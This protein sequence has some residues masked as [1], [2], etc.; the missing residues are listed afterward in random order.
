MSEFTWS[1]EYSVG[2]EEID[3]QHKMLFELLNRL[4]L[5]AVKREDQQLT[6]E[7]LQALV[8]YTKTHFGLEERLLEESGFAGV[9][10]HR[11]D[12][13]RFIAK[14]NDMM[15]KFQV[16]DRS[17]TF[18]LINFLKTWLR[19]HILHSDMEYAAH[20]ARIGFSPEA[21]AAGARIEVQAQAIQTRPWWKLWGDTAAG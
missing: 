12:H 14:V 7:V 8:D 15:R 4:F 6:I 20:L 2:V 5:A 17:V 18:E 16:E 21:W 1:N 3:N 13:L 19:N 10:G 11:E 9:P